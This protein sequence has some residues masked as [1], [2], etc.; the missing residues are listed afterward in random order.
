M[1]NLVAEFLFWP[2]ILVYLM[3]TDMGHKDVH[4]VKTD[5]HMNLCRLISL[6]YISLYYMHEA[7]LGM[8]LLNC[9]A[10]TYQTMQV[11]RLIWEFAKCAYFCEF[12]CE[13]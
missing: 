10:N 11:H 13:T 5:Q 12:G 3:I 1:T 6:H 2:S 9:S 7:T 4:A 8:W